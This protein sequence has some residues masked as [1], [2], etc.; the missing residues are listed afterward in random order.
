MFASQPLSTPTQVPPFYLGRQPILD[1]DGRTVAYELLFRPSRSDHVEVT[2]DRAATAAVIAHAYSDLGV[3][4]V[5]GDCQ[6]FVNFDARM[7]LSDIPE[8]LPPPSTVL[9]ILETV[10]FTR[11]LLKRCHELKERGFRFALDDVTEPREL[12]KQV[13][14]LVD[15]AKI[16]LAMTSFQRVPV[17]ARAAQDVG[18]RLLA[19]KVDSAYQADRC[20]ELGFELF[21]GYYFARPVLL[22]GR[23]TDPTR[24]VLLQLLNQIANERAREDIVATFKQAPELTYKLMRLVNSVGV[25]LPNRI[26]SL[27]HA[28]TVLGERQLRRWLQVLLFAH[29]DTGSFPSPL[30]TLAIT[31]ARLM[32]LIAERVSRDT[33]FRDQAFMTGIMS[34]LDTLLGTPMAQ[35]LEQISLGLEIQDALLHRGGRL[36]QMLALVE[37]L[38]RK[39][40]AELPRLA[41][42]DLVIE[43]PEL[44]ALQIAAMNLANEV[45]SLRAGTG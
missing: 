43:I 14:A 19:E 42:E 33:R 30:L 34:L 22:E 38:E 26:Q 13:L 25:G 27:A 29:H 16:D 28:L 36:G 24:Q 44:P 41:D 12:S 5:L 21:Q 17:I 7:L 9:E 40:V 8:L 1:R 2:D 15:I 6:G 45:V 4:T 31:R 23:R 18:V 10:K 20:R 35:L 39:D 3:G 37:A 11:A 32:E